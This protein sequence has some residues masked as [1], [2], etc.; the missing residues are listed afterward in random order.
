MHTIVIGEKYIQ[1]HDI[2]LY[3]LNGYKGVI[4]C[5]EDRRGGGLAVF[6]DSDFDFD[7][8]SICSEDYYSIS[9]VIKKIY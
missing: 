4:S 1:G 9:L 2:D 6:I 5:R 8:D 7:V 3:Y